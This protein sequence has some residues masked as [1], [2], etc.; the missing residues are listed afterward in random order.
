MLFVLS[1]AGLALTIVPCGARMAGAL[2]EAMLK[3]LMLVGTV[4][5]FAAAIARD[6]IKSRSQSIRG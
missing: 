5:W 2:D 3:H 1:L 6:T 4:L